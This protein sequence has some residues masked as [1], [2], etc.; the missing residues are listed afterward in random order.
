MSVS[1]RVRRRRRRLARLP[2]KPKKNLD[3]MRTKAKK[4]AHRIE[5]YATSARDTAGK[6]VVDAREWAAP[7][8]EHAAEAVQTTVAPKVTSA[9]SS[10]AERLEPTREE[11]KVRGT[12][13]LA[14]LKG[15]KVVKK[16]RRWTVAMFFFA[17]GGAVGAAA[18]VL[19]RKPEVLDEA[20]A[21]FSPNARTAGPPRPTVSPDAEPEGARP[22]E[23]A[24]VDGQ[25]RT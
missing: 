20:R 19:A 14:A 23:P 24:S 17:L 5:P 22:D 2:E 21:R 1:L 16:K 15:Q 13:A 25:I 11:A 8:L 18:A 6:R 9:L 10:A 4:T 12:A 3:L 7:R